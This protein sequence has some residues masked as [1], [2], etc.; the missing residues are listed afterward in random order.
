MNY[1]SGLMNTY[2]REIEKEG[3]RDLIEKKIYMTQMAPVM[4]GFASD[5]HTIPCLVHL[6]F[7]I[8]FICTLASKYKSQNI[9]CVILPINKY[10]NK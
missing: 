8:H 4:S 9:A 1:I 2:E 5:G 10:I 6:T 3:E 7:V